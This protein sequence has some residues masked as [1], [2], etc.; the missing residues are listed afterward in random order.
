MTHE[1]SI[2]PFSWQSRTSIKKK[3]FKQYISKFSLTVS[4]C[5]GLK[6]KAVQT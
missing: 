6:N 3:T 1:V 5:L 4:K 2:E